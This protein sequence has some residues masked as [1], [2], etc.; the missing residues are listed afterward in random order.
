MIRA[1]GFEDSWKI[2]C[3]TYD[4]ATNIRTE[5]TNLL[6]FASDI[7]GTFWTS[8]YIYQIYGQKIWDN[9]CIPFSPEHCHQR[10]QERRKKWVQFFNDVTERIINS[11]ENSED[12][13]TVPGHTNA[14]GPKGTPLFLVVLAL[15]LYFPQTHHLQ[16]VFPLSF[17]HTSM[18]MHKQHQPS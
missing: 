9:W 3:G 7:P 15:L 13:Q 18:C 17:T 10:H 8:V 11:K 5:P 1:L 2:F 16:K 14:C 6:T 4:N 12:F